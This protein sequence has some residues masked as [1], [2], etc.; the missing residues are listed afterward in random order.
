MV[1][2]SQG[3]NTLQVTLLFNSSDAT[4]EQVQEFVT[5]TFGNDIPYIMNDTLYQEAARH[6]Q[7]FKYPHLVV[8]DA[9]NKVVMQL[10]INEVRSS[11]DL[12]RVYQ[13][14]QWQQKEY[15]NKQLRKN[16]SF[17]HLNHVG[18][19]LFISDWGTSN[20]IYY[21]NTHTNKLD[22]IYLANAD[23]LINQLIAQKGFRGVDAQNVKKSFK[24][25]GF[26]YEIASFATHPRPIGNLYNNVLYIEFVEEKNLSDTVRPELLRYLFSFNPKTKKYIF[27]DYKSY[28]VDEY[29]EELEDDLRL[30][31]GHLERIHD[32][33]WMIGTEHINQFQSTPKTFAYLSKSPTDSVLFYKGEKLVIP[34][35]SLYDFDGQQMGNP[36][37]L[38][39]F[40]LMPSF[41]V[42][43]SSPYF[44][45]RSDNAI[46]NIRNFV[47]EATW[48]HDAQETENVL[49]FITEGNNLLYMSHIYKPTM[50][51]L[52]REYVCKV[53]E[54]K[55]NVLLDESLNAYFIQKSGVVSILKRKPLAPKK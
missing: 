20:K 47:P 48:I 5:T 8:M 4:A 26:P 32:T 14:H 30:E 41:L 45:R 12:L 22:S 35:D 42:Y 28:A 11:K 36:I 13:K 37:R 54:I 46:F 25:Y 18:E 50:Q 29:S 1:F 10:P 33:L 6:I 43:M 53:G 52:K 49:T 16:Y 2:G 15:A 51:L 19:Y 21:L 24:K 3:L 34:T 27:Y 7:F 9:T 31:Y 17:R 38:E 23:S 44:Y 55:S 39:F 40:K